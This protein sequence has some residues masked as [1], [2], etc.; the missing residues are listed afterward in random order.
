MKS[1]SHV[2]SNHVT[3]ANQARLQPVPAPT[4]QHDE[5]ILT[6]E[7]L[8]VRYPLGKKGFWGKVTYFDVLDNVS[9]S[10]GKGETL[11]LVGESGS[12]KSTIGRT[13]LRRIARTSGNITFE[14][15]DISDLHGEPLRK[16]RRRMQLIFQ[17]PYSSL[18]PRMNVMDIIAEPLLVHG[19]VRNAAEARAQ[20]LALLD[21]VSMPSTAA[22]RFPHQFSGGQR[23]R[24]GIARALALN[25]SFIVADEPVAA[26]DVSVRAQVVNL[27]QDLQEEL[28][29][30]ILF[31]AHDLSVVRHI[32]HRVAI[33]YAGQ[34]VEIGPRDAIYERPLHPYTKALLSAVPEPDPS[35]PLGRQQMARESNSVDLAGLGAGCRFYGRCPM[36]TDMCREQKPV[37]EVKDVGHSVACWKQ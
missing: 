19:L 36:A 17:D 4:A 37:L 35:I 23:Q 16:L 11:G 18:N 5:T 12:G 10:I 8:G 7:G 9:F 32:S 2:P 28:G 34:I 33:L 1:V 24:I 20:V 26:L 31:I 27:M 15:Q 3:A 30:S 22:E 13:V 25:P 21:R 14:G 29:I 6:V